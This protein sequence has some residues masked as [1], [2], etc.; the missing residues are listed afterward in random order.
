MKYD[1]RSLGMNRDISRRDFVNGVAV[2]AGVAATGGLAAL[3]G[4]TPAFGTEAAA[5]GTVGAVGTVGT[6]GG[7]GSASGYPPA[8]LGLRGSHPGSF[9]AA[10]ALRDSHHADL[11]GAENTG[12]TYDLVVVGGGLSGLGAA[13]YFLKNAGRDARVLVLENHDDFGGHAKRNE[14]VYQGK[15]LALNGG[16]LEIESPARYNKWARQLLDDIGVDL[17]RYKKANEA[18]EKLYAS[19]GLRSGHFFDKQTF[20]V[21]RL[22]VGPRRRAGGESHGPRFTAEYLRE[23]P[24]SEQAKRDLMRLEDPSQPDYLAGLSGAQKKEKLAHVSYKDYLLDIAKVDPQAYWFYRASGSGV[25]CVG[26]DALPALFAWQMG[27]G[28]GGFAGL[29]LDPSPEGLL[30]DLPGGQHGRQIESGE[31]VHFPDGNAT[32]ARLLVRWLI[33]AA[34]PG[35]TQEDL[36]TAH[37]KYELLDRPGNAARIRLNSTV[38]N[39]RHDGDL[40]TAKE[41][42]VSYNTGG[43][44]YQVRGRACVLACW[45]MVIPYLM[46][47]LPAAQKE[48]LAFNVKGPLV[49]T[50]VFLR[51]WR[52]FEKLG[53]SYI[54]APTM[55]HD[56]IALAEPADLGDLRHARNP[57]EPVAIRMTRFPGSPGL[58]RKDQHRIGRAELLATPFSTFERNIRE[59]LARTL[60]HGGFD[61]AR[62][63]VGIA[64]NRW[65]HGYSYTYNSLYDPVEWV[66][67]ESQKRPCVI[68]RQPFGLVSV[69]NADAAASPHTDAAFL[70]AH[71]AV[72]EV[73]DRRAFPFA[74][75]G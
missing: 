8:R 14:L 31:S 49:Y 72:T 39:V 5:A 71:R 11:S 13:H 53:V 63:I 65:P 6:D 26:A 64:V 54:E 43:K 67:T 32:L 74:R 38:V 51:N 2:A 58:P 37:V 20:G 48:A 33:P 35:S 41:V 59:Q 34:V 42:I 47:E 25:F 36:G 70:E 69:A 45:N 44:V 73:L 23:M 40:A 75:E 10:H 24:I 61:P 62:D 68:A 57:D 18:N 12:E 55:Y 66:F 15:L 52:A 29:K 22:V 50:N 4:S 16:T 28:A 27:E 1:D 60:G 21:D 56:T 46:P 30:A 9:E 19:F 7:A 17:E 3:G